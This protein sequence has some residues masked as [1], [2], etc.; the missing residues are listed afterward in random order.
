[1]LGVEIHICGSDEVVDSRS[2]SIW[3]WLM[4]RDIRPLT[5]RY[6][7]SA[8]SVLIRVGFSASTEAAAFAHRFGGKVVSV[9]DLSS[10][11]WAARDTINAA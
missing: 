3:K 4:Q 5:Y 2:T 8:K 7:F 11:D 6:M 1:M 9:K 10:P